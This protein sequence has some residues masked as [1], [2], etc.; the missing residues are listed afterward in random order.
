MISR[1][2]GAPWGECAGLWRTQRQARATPARARARATAPANPAIVTRDRKAG[3]SRPK[4]ASLL[5]WSKLSPRNPHESAGCNRIDSQSGGPFLIPSQ[6]HAA[7]APRRTRT[8]GKRAGA[9]TA[10]LHRHDRRVS[11]SPRAHSVPC[12]CAF[13]AGPHT[14]PHST[15]S[16]SSRFGQRE[17]QPSATRRLDDAL[18]C[19]ALVARHGVQVLN[20]LSS[21]SPRHLVQ[22]PAAIASLSRRMVLIV[23][24]IRRALSVVTNRQATFC[25]HQL[26]ACL[27]RNLSTTLRHRR[28][29]FTDSFLLLWKWR[30]G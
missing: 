4:F 27:V 26:G 13:A 18:A 7:L 6:E 1:C 16:R 30:V 15:P 23:S 29:L 22:I 2:R 20:L 21:R 17:H 19:A 8:S 9:V 12:W 14:S 11:A 3:Y 10:L 25:F 5:P 24:H 28:F